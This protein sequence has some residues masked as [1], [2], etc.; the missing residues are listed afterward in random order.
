MGVCGADPVAILEGM[1]NLS[2]IGS[3]EQ[4]TLE[5]LGFADN[6]RMAC[7]ARIQKGKIHVALKPQRASTKKIS[8]VENFNFDPSVEKVVIIG[9]GIAGITAADHIRRRHPKCE[10]HVVAKESHH[11]YNRMGLSRLIY[12]R[13][14]M[15]GLYLL[16]EDWYD[17]YGITIWL[18]TLVTKVDRDKKEIKLADGDALAYDRL[19][20]AMG[21]SG[22]VV[23]LRGFGMDGT[24]VLREAD[25]A[26]NIRA[27]AQ[28]YRCQQA[29]VSG[30]GLLG[31]EA[32]YALHKLGLEVTVLERGAW[33]MRRQLD[34]RG[35]TFLQQYLSGIGIDVLLQAEVERVQGTRRLHEV[36]LKDGRQLN[37]EIF[38]LCAGITP[39][40]QLAQGAGI[41][42]NR[43]ILVDDHM[44]TN[45]PDIFAVG[46]VAE[47]ESMI[48]GLWT[49][50]VEQGQVAA[51]N[52]VGGDGVYTPIVPTTMLKVAGIDL[53]SIGEFNPRTENDEVIVLEDI[54]QDEY[55]KLIIS[56]GR[57]IGAIL[58]GFPRLAPVVTEVI[59]SGTDICPVIDQLKDGEWDILKSIN[60]V[61]NYS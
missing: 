28:K 2:V 58:I 39:N 48:Y 40:I 8:S 31:L 50:S 12:G 57:I 6:T 1:D 9:N 17:D 42:V 22:R 29:V 56:K 49:V 33:L 44:R 34:E 51:I 35:A 47:F 37:T 14:A 54:E 43:G 60:P 32:A 21:S 61:P 27:Y 10:I 46:D 19:I 16:S 45:D 18:N 5:R 25:D 7:C 3:D 36:V 38:L 15:K 13:S 26:I 59:K 53:M 4:T 24:F 30:G 11:L 41:E 52:V 23:P 20:L 55:R